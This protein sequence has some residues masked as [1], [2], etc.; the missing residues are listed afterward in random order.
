MRANVNMH[1]PFDDRV[2]NVYHIDLFTLT[3]SI[4]VATVALS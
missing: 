2:V 1:L 4:A 3:C